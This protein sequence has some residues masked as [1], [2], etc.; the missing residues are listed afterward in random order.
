[1]HE[2]WRTKSTEPNIPTQFHSIKL[3][4]QNAPIWFYQTKSSLTS[5]INFMQQTLNEVKQSSSSSLSWAWPSTVPT[6]ILYS[7]EFFHIY[8]IFFSF[9]F[10]PEEEKKY[11]IEKIFFF[12]FFLWRWGGLLSFSKYSSSSFL[13]KKKKKSY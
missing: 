7:L 3:T 5:L 11:F 9:F 2:K 4:Q 8:R 10:P 1:M 12:F 13:L 6:C